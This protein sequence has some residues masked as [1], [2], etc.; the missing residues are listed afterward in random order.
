MN[1][2]ALIESHNIKQVRESAKI[3]YQTAE[4]RE[5]EKNQAVE[6]FMAAMG[7]WH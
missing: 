1:T 3:W 5:K 2:D 7:K 6:N 4:A